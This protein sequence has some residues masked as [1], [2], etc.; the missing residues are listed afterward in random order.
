MRHIHR[1]GICL[2]LVGALGCN[3]NTAGRTSSTSLPTSASSVA[4]KV[5]SVSIAGTATLSRGSRVQLRSF[6]HFADGGVTDITAQTLW[7]T[8][9][10]NVVE[11]EPE[12]WITG[13]GSGS[14]QIA[15]SFG[16]VEGAITLTVTGDTSAAN[17]SG[18]SSGT[19]IAGSAGS[20]SSPS[21]D[22]SDAGT[23]SSSSCLPPP[24][25]SNVPPPVPCPLPLP[26][27]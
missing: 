22:S 7:K 26:A 9:D 20:G 3:G 27:P 16:D 10:S 12:G 2:A 25:P 5:D 14:A 15:A 21:S 4:S 17:A 8:A 11:V 19:A 6:A 23:G 1:F 13:V 18:S 24:L